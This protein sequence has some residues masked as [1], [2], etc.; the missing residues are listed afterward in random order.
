M[1]RKLVVW[2]IEDEWK[3]EDEV[4]SDCEKYGY[5]LVSV[6]VKYI[7][8]REEFLVCAVVEEVSGDE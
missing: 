2:Q 6:S 3:I 4:N 7:K 8:W 5:N 1:K